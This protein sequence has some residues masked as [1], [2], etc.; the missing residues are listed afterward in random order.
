MTTTGWRCATCAAE[1]AIDQLLMWRCPGATDAHHV[2]VPQRPAGP[3][4]VVEHDDPFIAFDA[5]LAWSRCA[6][7][8]GLGVEDRRAI[9]DRLGLQFRRTPCHRHD[10]L[11]ARLGFTSAGGV[12]VKDETHQVGGSHKARHLMTIV[13]HLLTC[14]QVGAAP[15]DPHD[16]PRLAISSC[17]NA[18]IAA[19]TLAAAAS[20]PLDVMVPPTAGPGVLRML[21][22]LGAT[23]TLCPRLPDDPPGDPCLHRFR[24]AVAQGSI[25]FSVQGTENAWCLDG[26]RTLGWELPHGMDHVFLQ[27]GGGAFAASVGAAIVGTQPH[28]PRVHA[29]QTEGCAPLAR[30]W[31]RAQALAGGITSASQHWDECMW[32]W[33]S[34]LPSLADG[35]LDDETYDWL[36][37][38]DA[39]VATGGEPVVAT[40]AH[41]HDA[42]RLV[43]RDL[44]LAVSPTGTAG[45]AGLLSA[46]QH[47]DDD[48]K[49]L[50]VHSGVLR[51]TG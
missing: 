8:H 44:H 31:G 10:E 26:G 22:D 50:I 4:A 25:P 28:P 18:A 21:R 35:I 39:M 11:S 38:F 48:D 15:W 7:A 1:V 30:A 32:P 47:L 33:E 6:Q 27:V 5:E 34:S 37:V 12:W 46:R 13:L 3:L 17:G 20:W 36:G 41:I 16:R 49:V 42:H 45:L 51:P 43:T 2:L 14:E 40:E 29:V 9:L 19:A 24:E 23:V